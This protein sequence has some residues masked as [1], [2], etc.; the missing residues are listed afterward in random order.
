MS[1]WWVFS[2][3]ALAAIGASWGYI[4]TFWQY[5]SGIVFVRVYMQQEPNKVFL[6]R[7]YIESP[8]VKYGIG[9]TRVTSFH[10]NVKSEDRRRSILFHC[11]ADKF[12]IFISGFPVFVDTKP[13]KDRNDLTTFTFVRFTMKREKVLQ[14][15]QEGLREAF[16]YSGNTDRYF[17]LDIWGKRFEKDSS[18][19]TGASRS[20]QSDITPDLTFQ[21]PVIHDKND[22]GIS[23]QELVNDVFLNQ[24]Q[25]KVLS[26]LK[27]WKDSKKW[28][29]ER[30]IVWRRGLLLH[31]LP[32]TGKTSFARKVATEL[33]IPILRFN[34]LSF[35]NKDFQQC[36]KSNVSQYTP[37]IVLFE[38]F[39]AIFNGRQNI[40]GNGSLS[41]DLPLT[42]DCLLNTIDG[43][44]IMQGY[45]LM[46][47]TNFPEKIDGAL[48]C[49]QME[50]SARPGRI[51]IVMEFGPLSETGRIEIAS[52]ILKGF[53]ELVNQVVKDGEGET[54]AQF[55]ERCCQLAYGMYNKEVSNSC[56]RT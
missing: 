49:T 23:P 14:F 45:I 41:N 39:D 26:D 53:D 50:K 16:H 12:F 31:G 17:I 52:R 32:G 38:D 2:G 3:A 44:E 42:F 19:G 27:S 28:F 4:K 47:T 36:F 35:N 30:G 22:L 5:I 33:S 55:K 46:I 56:M 24:E 34:L 13:D 15:I 43:V 9:P 11:L 37:C 7:K 20:E 48:A 8:L 21:Y 10:Y 51:D 6:M 40:T 29:T 18:G 25:E 54:G 1:G